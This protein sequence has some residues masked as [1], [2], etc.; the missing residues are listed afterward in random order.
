MV[1]V[2]KQC[3]KRKQNERCVPAIRTIARS[4]GMELYQSF[5]KNDFSVPHSPF[6]DSFILTNRLYRIESKFDLEYLY[7]YGHYLFK[8]AS[9]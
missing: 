4:N 2:N 8:I 3:H 6:S 7:I 5:A 9:T 1:P